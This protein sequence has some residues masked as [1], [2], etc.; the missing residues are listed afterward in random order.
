ML[1]GLNNKYLLIIISFGALLFSCNMGQKYVNNHN[2]QIDFFTKE[3]CNTLRKDYAL[4]DILGNGAHEIYYIPAN[5]FSLEKGNLPFQ[6]PKEIYGKEMC[7]YVV[8]QNEENETKFIYGSCKSGLIDSNFKNDLF[9]YGPDELLEIKKLSG[10]TKVS[11]EC[12]NDKKTVY[13]NILEGTVLELENAKRY[14]W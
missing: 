2:N 4:S 5:S 11:I 9:I 13:L 6:I 7:S 12:E 14:E 8:F 3:V 10:R 1:N